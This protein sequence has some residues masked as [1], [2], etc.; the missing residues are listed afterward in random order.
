MA[1]VRVSSKK[2]LE[3]ITFHYTNPDMVKDLLSFIP[4]E[5]GDKVL[6]AG[7]GRNKVWYNLLPDYVK[8]YECEI[9]D[10]CDFLQWTE[11][12]DW[13]IGNPP[14]NILHKFLEKAITV[15]NKGIAF[16]LSIRGFNGLTPR[17]LEFYKKNGFYINKIH[18]VSDKRWFGRYYFTIL[19]KKQS[20]FI[21]WNLK[22]Y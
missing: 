20:D 5:E 10:G 18:I 15:S 21:T 22:S 16:L 3:D 4:F 2:G 13:V 17:R 19:T 14:F 9:E 7:S 8:K 1:N 11:K 6:D 12:V